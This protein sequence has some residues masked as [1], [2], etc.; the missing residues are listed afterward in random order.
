MLHE[1]KTCRLLRQ[2]QTTGQQNDSQNWNLK[3]QAEPHQA[4]KPMLMATPLLTGV[5]TSLF[6]DFVVRFFILV[7][8]ATGH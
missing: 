4:G 5:R 1:T 3:S 8:L 6:H 7:P 2:S